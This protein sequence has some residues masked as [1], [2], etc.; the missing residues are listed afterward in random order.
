L[1]LNC[2]ETVKQVIKVGL[3]YNYFYIVYY[4][5]CGVIATSQF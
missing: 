5:L 2:N 4:A 3:H 1:N